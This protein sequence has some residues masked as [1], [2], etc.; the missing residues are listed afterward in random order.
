MGVI[1]EDIGGGTAAGGGVAISAAASS[2]S[3]GTVVFSNSNNV[4]FGLNGSTITA[5]ASSPP[6]TPFGISAGT[7]SV[8]TGT[9]V[10]SNSNNFT[11]G[12][13]GSS[14]VT[15]S[16]TAPVVSNA[17]QSVGSATGSG[18]NTSRFAADDHV[19]AGV[20]SMGV[21]TGGNTAGD[22]RVDVGRFVLAGGANITLSQGTAANALNTISIVGAAGGGGGAALSAGTQ[23]GNTGTILFA[24]SNGITF[25]M[26]GSTRITASYSV[27]VV[28]N[29][30]QSVS[31]A[32]NSGT[33]TSR[34][35][36]DDHVH[37]GVFSVGV[38]TDGNTAGNTRVDV[39]RFVFQGSDNIT[40]SQSTAA[41]ALNTIIIKGATVAGGN[42]S[43]GVSTMGNTDGS[44][45][46]VSGQVLFVGTGG[47]S[48]SQSTNGGSATITFSTPIPATLSHYIPFGAL[49]R[50]AFVA[51]SN[52]SRSFYPMPIPCY[53]SFSQVL[54]PIHVSMSTSSNS[55]WGGTLSL[56]LAIYTRN[57]STL[58]MASSATQ[59][60]AFTNTSN[61]STSVLSGHRNLTVPLSANMTPG[62]YWFYT[63][64]QSSTTNANW[65]TVSNIMIDGNSQGSL[66]Q[67]LFAVESSNATRQAILGMGSAGATSVTSAPASQAFSDITGSFSRW[68][69]PRFVFNNFTA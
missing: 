24:D 12:M 69:L 63:R 23:S 54:V 58:S 68:Q 3:A 36:A 2:V 62:D 31:S 49:G 34:F 28:S 66:Y 14:R 15:A 33:N 21:S 42:F 8:S 37:A 59:T 40:L 35:A 46:T 52:G 11:F 20:F 50:E 56:L 22:T 32:T 1:Y 27:P 26:S 13:S 44:T 10:F 16:Y 51:M 43:A 9:L 38:S 30:I 4:S 48:L 29:A 64:M 47:I 25:G 6:E 60:W 55:S 65:F 41:N 17:I 7:Q 5:T 53:L 67:G 18:T 45:G 19:H 57:N 61:N 39:G